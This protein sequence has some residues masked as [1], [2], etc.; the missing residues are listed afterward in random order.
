MVG[1]RIE[2]ARLPDQGQSATPSVQSMTPEALSGGANGLSFEAVF[3]SSN[4]TR[5]IGFRG[6]APAGEVSGSC[7][8]AEERWRD[9][10]ST[11]DAA[12]RIIQVA[13][14]CTFAPFAGP[15]STSLHVDIDGALLPQWADIRRRVEQLVASFV[16]SAARSPSR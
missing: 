5:R 2:Q 12:M 11:G 6:S 1:I 4:T 7:F 13:S 9:Q 16:A 3:G 15:G 8:L 14:Q 10:L